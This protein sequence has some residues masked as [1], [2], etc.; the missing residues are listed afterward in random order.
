MN[1]P[2]TIPS[3]A[4]AA[5]NSSLTTMTHKALIIDAKTVTTKTATAITE[6]N[7]STKISFMTIS[8]PTKI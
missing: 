8:E 6:T 4:T 1:A 3:V 5:S 2:P 7:I